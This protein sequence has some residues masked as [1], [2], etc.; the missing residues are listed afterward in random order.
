MALGG[1]DTV[2]FDMDGTIS[3]SEAL[4]LDAAERG[5]ARFYA[6]LG[7]PAE[8]PKRAEIR[9]MIGLPSSAY[10]AKLLPDRLSGR[11]A[12]VRR[13]VLALEIE[14]LE[15]GR[16]G[17]FA[18]TADSLMALK[19]AGLK[20]GLVTNGGRGYFDATWKALG[21]ESFFSVGLCIDDAPGGTK[22]DL[23]KRA[24]ASLGTLR[25]A[26]V[27]DK[28]YDIDAGRANGFSTIGCTWGYGSPGEL[29]GADHLID[30][31]RRLPPLL[32]IGA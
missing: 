17:M 23:V 19:H 1:V 13:H 16:G 3:S 24:A 22:S 29:A 25:G 10:F 20:L 31:I 12:D 15:E 4:A 27:G 26:M 8:V 28:V 7:E 14:A 6:E 21:L 11:W 9:A 5:L 30:D 2:L 18:G 32:G